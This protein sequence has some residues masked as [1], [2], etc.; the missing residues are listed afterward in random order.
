[1]LARVRS[2]AVLGIDAYIVDVESDIAH[3]LP[4]FATVGLPHG[5]V[6]EGRERVGAAI[7]NA[8]FEF[9]LRRIT[10]NLAPADIRKDGSAF[11]L[12]IALGILAA[13][14]QLRV[15]HA[16][17][18]VDDARAQLPNLDDYLVVGELGLEGELRPVRGALSVALAARDAGMQGVVLPHQNIAEA[19][20]VRGVAVLGAT[21]LGEVAGFFAGRNALTAP[22]RNG[23]KPPAARRADAV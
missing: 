8:G 22:N 20:V 16:M 6:R 15:P 4:S 17:T 1:M 21:S 9:P 18:T 7:V 11:D 19:S 12:P 2:A 13:T 3:G 10:I 5:A 14:G 23:G